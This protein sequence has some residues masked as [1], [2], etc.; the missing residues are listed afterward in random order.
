MRHPE[1]EE[2]IEAQ[3]RLLMSVLQEHGEYSKEYVDAESELEALET[4]LEMLMLEDRKKGTMVNPATVE[5]MVRTIK[6]RKTTEYIFLETKDYE[7][8]WFMM[9]VGR[10]CRKAKVGLYDFPHP[11]ADCFAEEIIV[12][13]EVDIEKVVRKMLD[14]FVEGTEL[15]V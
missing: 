7:E 11:E 14:E 4:E 8:Y 12:L 15:E 13:D 6:E 3:D 1:L 9:E 2:R 10:N 5:K